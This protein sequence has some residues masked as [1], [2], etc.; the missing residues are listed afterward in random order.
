MEII[1]ISESVSI[2]EALKIFEN[3]LNYLIKKFGDNV[4]ITTNC[5]LGSILLDLPSFDPM[6]VC[7]I[8]NHYIYRSGTYSKCDLYINSTM[9]YTDNR[10]ILDN[11]TETM[12]ISVIDHNMILI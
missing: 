1:K 9:K 2:A 11:G 10:F 5:Y 8:S 7:E 12:E 3:D 4:K 6:P